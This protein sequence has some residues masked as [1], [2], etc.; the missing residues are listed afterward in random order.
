MHSDTFEAHLDAEVIVLTVAGNQSA[1]LGTA[2][3]I[4]LSNKPSEMLQEYAQPVF[5]EANKIARD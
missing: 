2:P 5:D 3:S 4:A 1:I